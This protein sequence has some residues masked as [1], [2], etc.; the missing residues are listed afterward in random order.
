[1]TAISNVSTLLRDPTSRIAGVRQNR[2]V[3]RAGWFVGT[4]LLA[5]VYFHFVQHSARTS[6]D[7]HG[8][9]AGY[10]M[11]HGNPLLS[12]WTLS[13][14]TFV[15]IEMP[16]MGLVWALTGS[17]TLA[18]FLPAAIL[19]ALVIVL[20]IVSAAALR[21][22][23]PIYAGVVVFVLLGLP[24][25]GAIP[26]LVASH[27]PSHTGIVV[28]TLLV[29]LLAQRYF[30]PGTRGAII[31]LLMTAILF[32]STLN[33]PMTLL[34]AAGP[35]I[36]VGGLRYRQPKA[37]HLVA[38]AIA[39]VL[40][41]SF[42]LHVITA[43]GGYTQDLLPTVITQFDQLANHLY[44]VTLSFLIIAGSNFFGMNVNS[45]AYASF[46]DYLAVGPPVRLLRCVLFLLLA[47]TF[48]RSRREIVTNGQLLEHL[49]LVGAVLTIVAA[50]F[51]NVM[52]DLTGA[53]YVLPALVLLAIPAAA[54][55]SD[56]V[57]TVRFFAAVATLSVL[58]V[59]ASFLWLRHN[60]QVYDHSKESI[61]AY[62][63]REHL[64]DGY[65]PYWSAGVVTADSSGRVRARPV[66]ATA[67]SI[68]PNPWLANS[69]WFTKV[70]KG[71]ERFVL[72]NH[73]M[74][75]QDFGEVEAERAF[76]K[77]ERTEQF[78]SYTILIYRGGTANLSSVGG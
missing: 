31:P 50:L 28:A 43:V 77:P 61:A 16:L 35:L 60:P 32:I 46:G 66:F 56:S 8:A 49:C 14:D 9:L 27:I 63:E 33:D 58:A 65:A 4:L 13:S 59:P 55:L 72:V 44:L 57:P 1:V 74:M 18:M 45:S 47:F 52:L 30:D 40:I 69:H 38:A 11:F 75:P 15:T 78:E 21:P 64:T 26:D 3:R 36:V 29:F 37:L 42:T 19:W 53:R 62:L 54:R 70:P 41:S 5:L 68:V 73:Q 7:A 34:T 17:G 24:L 76:G 25:I 10:D 67:T 39:G 2:W 6:D 71:S 51:T 20:S 12:G 23:R 48:Y 22:T